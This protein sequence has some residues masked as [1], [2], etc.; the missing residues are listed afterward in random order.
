[1]I[2]VAAHAQGAFTFNTRNLTGDPQKN[3]RFTGLDGS[4]LSGADLFVQVW[5]GPAS[6]GVAGLQPLAGPLPLNR[7]GNGA[8]YTNPFLQTYTTS[9][10]GDALIAY[11]A[12]QGSSWD[13]A[14]LRSAQIT[15]QNGDQGGAALQVALQVAPNLPQEVALGA[16]SVALIPEPTT[17]ALGLIGL[18]GLLAFRRRQ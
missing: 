10:T 16:G 12:Y 6:A 11:G 9:F 4:F 13:T 7:T 5:A 14:T 18:G 2:A 15:T 8:G 1:M 17:I 3:I